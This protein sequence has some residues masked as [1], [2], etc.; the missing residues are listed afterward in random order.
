MVPLF[1]LGAAAGVTSLITAAL[2]IDKKSS[3][4]EDYFDLFQKDN[5]QKTDGTKE[6]IERQ[7]NKLFFAL[8]YI[9]NK[10]YYKAL[11]IPD[12]GTIFY[13]NDNKKKYVNTFLLK[14]RYNDY[15]DSIFK[16]AAYTILLKRNCEYVNLI[17]NFR[18]V[19][20]KANLRLKELSQ[21]SVYFQDLCLETIPSLKQNYVTNNRFEWREELKKASKELVS[22]VDKALIKVDYLLDS[23]CF[24]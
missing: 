19:I 16:E 1:L 5:H 9:K 18:P 17:E 23:I 15:L 6:D 20:K 24:C 12:K 2:L 22:Y 4:N 14:G 3:E 13:F 8:N 21:N 11:D 10:S 7:L